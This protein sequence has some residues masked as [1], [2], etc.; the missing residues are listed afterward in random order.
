MPTLR[1]PSFLLFFLLLFISLQSY[2]QKQAKAICIAF[3]NQENLY[4]TIDDPKTNDAE[5]TPTGSNS[6]TWERYQ[7][8]LAHMSTV[9]SQIGD[10]FLKGG[11]TLIGLS[12]IENRG[13]LEDLIHTEALKNSGYGI[14]HFESPDLRGVDVAL[15]YKKKDFE[16]VNSVAVPMI[17][18]GQPDFKTRDQLVVTGLVDRDTMTI[19]V[20]H[21][22]SRGNDVTHR[23]AAAKLTHEIVDSLYARNRNANI[24]VMGDLNDDPIDESVLVTLGARGKEEK[25]KSG[26]L[27]N[28]MW[29]MF[30]D[31]TGS[32][33]YKDSWNLFD[34]IIVSEP[35]IRTG[36]SS[37]KLYK[38]KVFK[39]PFMIQPDGQYAGYPFRTFA[40]GAY[41]NGYSDHLPVYVILVKAK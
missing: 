6:W 2:S 40:G 39:K 7:S 9:I 41:V 4:D 17:M 14:A 12:E 8:K 23:I 28:P 11:P 19:V 20:N 33:A 36:Q 34:Q 24:L 38:T 21:W 1:I 16:L 5:F 31:G 22:P 27:Y 25:T 32:L 35:L 30:K 10:E 26:E 3:Y 37:W 13:V 29:Q 18:P 15:L